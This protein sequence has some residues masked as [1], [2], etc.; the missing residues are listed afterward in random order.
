MRI[1]A[2]SPEA[3]GKVRAL[4]ALVADLP[5][6]DIATEHLI[7]AGM[8]ARTI[9]IPTGV[10]LTGAEIKLATVLIVSGHVSVYLDGQSV[11]LVGHHVIPASKGRKQAFVAH[12]DT[13]LTMLFPT[14]AITIEQAEDQFTD[15]AHRLM[16]RSG[17]NHVH[18]TG[19]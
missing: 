11:E 18:I 3:I 9:T 19:E 7:H 15:E 16:S 6:E 5:Q 8:Y 14:D 2:M 1:A 17:V 4:E 10:M 12:A 13:R